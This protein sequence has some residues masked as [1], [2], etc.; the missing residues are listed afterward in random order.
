[1]A[2][3]CCCPK[4]SQCNTGTVPDGWTVVIGGMDVTIGCTSCTSGSVKW[5]GSGTINGTYTLK[6]GKYNC[7]G[8]SICGGASWIGSGL[9]AQL[10]SDSS[11]TTAVA[12]ITRFCL[13]IANAGGG[14]ANVQITGYAGITPYILFQASV[15]ASPGGNCLTVGAAN[16]T[17]LTSPVCGYVPSVATVGVT[18]VAATRCLCNCPSYCPNGAPCSWTVIISGSTV[19][20]ANCFDPGALSPALGLMWGTPGSWDGEYCVPNTTGCSGIVTIPGPT[21]TEYYGTTGP[22]PDCS[23]SSTSQSAWQLYVGISAGSLEVT[24]SG[25]PYP[26]PALNVFDGVAAIDSCFEGTSLIN[27]AGP[28]PGLISAGSFTVIPHSSTDCT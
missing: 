5:S 15:P 27:S 3:K 13:S 17:M 11:C 6:A 26:F 25:W 22:P 9:T 12:N 16:N 10:Y 19:N 23:G 4:C 24:L 7:G 20:T 14:V 18:P 8:V 28:F 21:L 1:M 2:C